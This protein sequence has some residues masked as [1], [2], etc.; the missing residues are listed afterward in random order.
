MK[1]AP[2]RL[3]GQKTAIVSTMIQAASLMKIDVN[4]L[5]RKIGRR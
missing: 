4:R 5:H 1:L 2:R 3:L